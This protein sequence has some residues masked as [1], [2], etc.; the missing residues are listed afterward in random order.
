MESALA[1]YLTFNGNAK[2]AMKL[3]HSILGGELKMQTFGESKMART[4]GENDLI[5]HATLKG[6]ALAFMASDSMPGRRV[7][8]GD[9][10]HMS[11]NG[12]DARKLTEIFNRLAEGGKVDLPFAKQFW[13]TPT[14]RSQTGLA[15]TGW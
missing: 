11:L 4:P 13:G 2:E 15:F 3:Y 5:I 8:F 9:N 1:P 6:E 12:Q 10:V 7:T 14:G